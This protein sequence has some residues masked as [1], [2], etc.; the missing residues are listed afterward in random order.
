MPGSFDNPI[1]LDP[2]QDIIAFH[3]PEDDDDDPVDDRE[4]TGSIV[5]VNPSDTSASETCSNP[6]DPGGSEFAENYIA[7]ITGTIGGPPDHPHEFFINEIGGGASRRVTS[8][9][10]PKVQETVDLTSWEWGR[11]LGIEVDHSGTMGTYRI[12]AE[13]LG[14]QQCLPWPLPGG[15]LGAELTGQ[16]GTVKEWQV[17]Y[18]SVLLRGVEGWAWGDLDY[19]AIRLEETTTLISSGSQTVRVPALRVVV[20][21]IPREETS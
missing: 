18:S 6:Q 13:V 9:S 21:S 5:T 19:I 2:F 3:V 14:Q 7:S 10:W 17:D 20:K 16:R 15:R 1:R 8:I 11:N 12:T 4:F